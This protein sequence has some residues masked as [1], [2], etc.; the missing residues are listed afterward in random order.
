MKRITNEAI[1]SEMATELLN[2]RRDFLK[3]LGGGIIV[4][5]TVGKLSILDSFA[6]NTNLETLNFKEI[7]FNG[8]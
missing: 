2:S 5:F 6:Q 8:V 3:K 7:S 4:A 1:T